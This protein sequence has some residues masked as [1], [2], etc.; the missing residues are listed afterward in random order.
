M[1]CVKYARPKIPKQEGNKQEGKDNFTRTPREERNRPQETNRFRGQ[2]EE[3]PRWNRNSEENQ[4]QRG[5]DKRQGFERHNNYQSGPRNFGNRDGNDFQKRE[6]RATKNFDGGNRGQGGFNKPET[7]YQPSSA[8][9][10]ATE[11]L[12]Y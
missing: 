11:D 4:E 6:D 7:S 9:K 2:Q 8:S 10:K 12:D 5:G 1:I 3:R